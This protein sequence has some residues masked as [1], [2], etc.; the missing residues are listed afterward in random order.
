VSTEK[1]ANLVIE[2]LLT[3]TSS[4]K[5]VQLVEDKNPSESLLQSLVLKEIVEK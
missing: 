5:S 2:F 4:A 1:E 3:V